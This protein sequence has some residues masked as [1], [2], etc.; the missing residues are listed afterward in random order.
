[1]T[2]PS[3]RAGFARDLVHDLIN[4]MASLAGLVD[5]LLSPA[6]KEPLT[7]RQQRVLSTM[8]RACAHYLGVLRDIADAASLQEGSWAPE[9]TA[10]DLHATAARTVAVYARPA[11]HRHIALTL[12]DGG[13]AVVEADQEMAEKFFDALVR[14]AGRLTPDGGRIALRFFREKDAWAG[15][16]THSG[17]LPPADAYESA[18]NTTLE[19]ARPAEGYAVLGMAVARRIAVLHGGGLDAQP[20]SDGARFRFRFP[21]P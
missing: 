15:E 17:R 8:E 11:A 14:A 5:L 9:K 6:A 19:D 3:E 1:M 4:P 7:H 18:F 12:E 21:A 13:P 16:L 2:A 20:V 10:V